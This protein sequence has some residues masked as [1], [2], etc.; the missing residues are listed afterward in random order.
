M[1][2][3][4]PQSATTEQLNAWAG[5][6]GRA[7]TDRNVIDWRQRYQAYREILNGLLIRS[8]LEVGCNRGHNLVALRELLEGEAEVVGVE[9]NTYARQL[10]IVN[11]GVRAV[12]GDAFHLPFANQ[13]FELV[14]TSG[15]L[16]HVA[17][18]DLVRAMNE[19]YRVSRRYIL[20]VEYFAEQE[21]VISYRGRDD[22]LWKRDFR[23]HYQEHFPSLRL[24][25]SGHWT[26]SEEDADWWLFEKTCQ[27]GTCV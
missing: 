20:C 14:F 5:D 26:W 12:E 21:T 10:A 8:A 13:S 22:L 25:R 3:G 17:P 7:Y 24:M 23:R 11:A 6:F 16:I 1:T 15:V 18:A 9:P 4:I 27:E 19:I 2:T